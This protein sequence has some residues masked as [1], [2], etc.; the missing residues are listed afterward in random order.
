MPNDPK[1]QT[2]DWSKVTQSDNV[3]DIHTM[4]TSLSEETILSKGNNDLIGW[5]TFSKHPEEEKKH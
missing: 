3:S 1:E 2:V 4:N 5:E